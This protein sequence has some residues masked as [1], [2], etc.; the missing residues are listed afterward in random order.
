MSNKRALAV[1][2]LT[3][4]LSAGILAT[5]ITPAAAQGTPVGGSGN[6]FYLT[7]AGNNTGQPVHAFAYGDAGDEV[8]FGDFFNAATGAMT[9]DGKDDALVRRG[10]SFILRGTNDTIFVYGDKGDTVLAGDWDGNGTDSLAVKRGNHYFVKNTLSTGYSDSDFFYGDAAD[11]V[12]VGNW[13]G[14]LTTNK[15]DTIAV[16]RDNH[17]YIR[18]A[19]TTGYSEYDFFYGNV[20]DSYLVG[21]WAKAP[22][23]VLDDPNTTKDESKQYEAA[24][25]AAGTSRDESKTVVAPKVAVGG[26]AVNATGA[27]Q[28][29][30]KRGNVYLFSDE[31]A[32]M[33]PSAPSAAV[34]QLA[35]LWTMNFGE[36]SDVA[37]TAKAE[38]VFDYQENSTT[39]YGTVTATPVTGDGIGI[40]RVIG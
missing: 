39:D 11:K 2:F 13:D 14:N 1:G 26:A 16:Q 5:A 38:K 9:G 21:D 32:A 3:A 37:F 4:G 23:Y 40:R 6:G 24:S 27:D 7:G 33:K 22:T 34:G 25:D 36:A 15:T 8:Y 29:A 12:L 30:I 35:S 19:L 20:G 10:N 28:L 18:N 17:F 31:V